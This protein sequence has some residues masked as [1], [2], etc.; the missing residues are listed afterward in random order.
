MPPDPTGQA[1][2]DKD[3]PLNFRPGETLC[4]AASIAKL[5]LAL[6]VHGDARKTTPLL[7]DGPHMR[8]MSHATADRLFASTAL[9]ALGEETASTLSLHGGRIFLAV[10]LRANDEDIPTV[11]ACCRWL[12]DAS[13]KRYSHLT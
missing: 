2:R 7:T 13:A 10:A 9:E 12:T 3:V 6:P 4:A 8:C 5:E 1:F 11:Q